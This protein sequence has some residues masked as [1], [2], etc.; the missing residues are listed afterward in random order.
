MGMASVM[1]AHQR[2]RPNEM[3][4]LG[5]IVQSSVCTELPA[6]FHGLALSHVGKKG[7]LASAIDLHAKLALMLRAE[8]CRSLGKNLPQ[9][10]HK[11][12]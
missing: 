2:N 7:D 5:R 10:I 8:A 12:L 11:L 6:H 4:S 1:L 3:N 9:T